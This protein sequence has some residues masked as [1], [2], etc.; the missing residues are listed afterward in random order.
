MKDVI[1][2]KKTKQTCAKCGTQHSIPDSMYVY[3]CQTCNNHN[4]NMNKFIRK[5]DERKFD[6]FRFAFDLQ[7]KL[8]SMC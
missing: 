2:M 6:K 8:N 1:N 7:R 3:I 5:D 4:L